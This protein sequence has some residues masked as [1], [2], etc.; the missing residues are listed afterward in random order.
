MEPA[1][2][3]RPRLTVLTVVKNGA[4]DLPRCLASVDAQAWPAL[5]HVVVDGASTDGTLELLRRAAGPRRRVVSEPDEGLYDAMNKG[6]D[7]ATGDFVLFLGADDVLRCDL[8]DVAPRLVDPGTV[9]YGDVW[10]VGARRRYDGPF[11]ARKLA[12]HNI[13]HQAIF[14]PR[15]ALARHRFARR[16]RWLADWELNM[17]CFSDPALA[18]EHLPV[19]VADYEDRRGLSSTRRDEALERDYL[20]LL[21]RHFAW[22]VALRASALKLAERALL[23]A[24]LGGL[25]RR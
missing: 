19:L 16:Y 9:Y 2:P 20:R 3:P 4:A 7:L 22:P 8:A 23:A 15:A 11:D 13:C 25:L 18:F 14:Y 24:G 1:P 5:E 12:H 21:W 10:L 6:I 17:R